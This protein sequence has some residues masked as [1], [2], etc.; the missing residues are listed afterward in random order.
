VVD[1][2]AMIAQVTSA[3]LSALGYETVVAHSR[4]EAVQRYREEGETLSLVIM[5]LTM[6]DGGELPLLVRLMP[7]TP[8]QRSSS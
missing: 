2:E 5:D 4:A 3:M 6:P 7:S 1:D 8:R